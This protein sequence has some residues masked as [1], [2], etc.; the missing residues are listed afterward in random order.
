MYETVPVALADFDL[1][2]VSA[3]AYDEFTL[4]DD[5]Q[6]GFKSPDPAE[7]GG[8]GCE[9]GAPCAAGPPSSTLSARVRSVF[10]A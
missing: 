4:S 2:E 10:G 5:A 7:N 9:E 1:G 6:S 8:G 3:L